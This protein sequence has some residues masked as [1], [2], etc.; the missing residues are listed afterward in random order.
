MIPYVLHVAL[1]LD[2]CLLFYKLLLQKE[3]YYRLNR[4]IL[5]GCLAAAFLLPL[6]QVPQQWALR[7]SPPA[8]AADPIPVVAIR[9]PQVTPAPS[10]SPKATP[11]ATKAEVKVQEPEVPLMQ[12]VITWAFYLYWFGV[13]AFGANMLL[14]IGVLLLQTRRRPVIVDG[15]YRIVELDDDKAPCSFGNSIFINPTKYEPDTFDQILL[16]EKVHIKQ[17]H[18]LDLLLA[19]LMLAFQWFNPFAWLYRKEVESNLEYLADNEVLHHA[20]V[21]R[22]DY[23][24]NL[25]KVSVPNLS[26]RITTNY[27]QSLLKK[28]IVMMNAKRSNIH[29]AWKYLFLAPMMVFLVCALN[30]PAASTEIANNNKNINYAPAPK[31]AIDNEGN[32]KATIKGSKLELKLYEEGEKNHMSNSDFLVSEFTALPKGEEGSFKL[33]REAGTMQFTGRFDGATGSGKYKFTPDASFKSYM[34]AEGLTNISD[35]D[36]MAFFFLNI[37]K[38]YVAMLKGNGYKTPSKDDVIACK[39]LGVDDAYIK[40]MKKNGFPNVKLQEL[41]SGKALGI[42]GAYIADIHKA[43]YPNVSWDKLISFKAQGIDSKY[44][45]KFKAAN[46]KP[47]VVKKGASEDDMVAFKALDVSDEYINSLKKEGYTN[48]STDKLTGM[49]ALGIDGDYIHGF[50]AAGFNKLTAD[51]LMSMKA[52]GITPQFMTSF[53]AAGYPSLTV[54]QASSAKALGITADYLSSFKKI[55]YNNMSLEQ[56][57]SVKALGITPEYLDSFKDAGYKITL[58]NA[59]SLKALGVTPE[60]LK[61][62]KAIGYDVT[63][64]QASSLKA[65]GVTPEYVTQMKEKGFKS[66]DINKYITLKAAF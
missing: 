6:I 17:K 57:S 52:L 62:F 53:K 23:Q 58:D 2:I 41:I 30:E 12:R 39:A 19:E 25:L 33:V 60:F 47:G 42:T 31:A 37:T 21:E 9:L 13:I 27:N 29:T 63:I 51:N 11:P 34:K 45:N 56:A 38:G 61:G 24:M 26:L 16:H 59:S 14:Q 1:L 28:R 65:M 10:Y 44:I 20:T 66:D 18:S 8:V 46:G 4:V 48:L 3:T 43:G 54:E 40:S 35:D 64:D 50:K 22:S 49:K 55:G 32:W 7:Q 5:L 36:D 15:Q